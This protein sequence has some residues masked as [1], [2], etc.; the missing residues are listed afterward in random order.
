MNSIITNSSLKDIKSNIDEYIK[1]FL[2]NGLLIFPSINLYDREQLD[3]MHLFGQKLNWGYIDKSYTEDHMVTFEMIKDDERSADDLFIGWHLEHVERPRPQV[4]ASWNM[5]KFTCSNEFGA[6]GFIDSSALYYRLNDDWQAFLD[7]C[8]IKNPYSLNTER[9][10]VISHSNN[11]KKILRLDPYP[12][13]EILCRVG[14]S[15][16]SSLDIKLYQ[17]ITQWVSK[18][19]VEKQQDSFWWNWS[20]GDFILIDL[21]RMVHAVKGGFLP[22]ERSFSRHWAYQ[23]KVDYKLYS[24]PMFHKGASLG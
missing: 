13:D 11:G 8:F 24:K 3:F 17:E 7:N 23:D 10:C 2:E 14:I 18:E 21:S 5:D 20:E 9:P 1:L 22:E 12:G 15:E 6:T 19:I 4:A 16:P